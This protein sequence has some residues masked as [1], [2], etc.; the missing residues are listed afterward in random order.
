M[1]TYRHQVN[2][3]CSLTLSQTFKPRH[4]SKSSR[5]SDLNR[6]NTAMLE[7]LGSTLKF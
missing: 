4:L 6:P 1:L 7:F 3:E 5:I 2:V